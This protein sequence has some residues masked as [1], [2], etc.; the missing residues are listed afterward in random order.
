LIGTIHALPII[1]AR[2]GFAKRTA[3]SG[4]AVHFI[5]YSYSAKGAYREEMRIFGH[6]RVT[7]FLNRLQQRVG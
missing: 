4:I 1:P 7:Y 3:H 5:K 6:S 2:I